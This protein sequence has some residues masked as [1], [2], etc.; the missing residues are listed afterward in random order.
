M[1]KFFSPKVS[2]VIPVYNVEKYLVRCLDSVV[3]IP[4]SGVEVILINDC[5][6]DQS[7]GI[8]D[9]YT[10]RENVRCI[11]H[12]ENKG[13]SAARNTG[14]RA[15]RGKYI[16]FIDGDDFIYPEHVEEVL[17]RAEEMDIEVVATNPIFE[18][19]GNIRRV[20]NR[21]IELEMPCRGID[22]FFKY[23]SP[24]IWN[25]LYRKS[26]LL[27]NSLLFYEGIIH[28]DEEFTPRALALCKRLLYVD[29]PLYHYV[30]QRE[31]SLTSKSAREV[32]IKIQNLDIIIHSL[33][34][35]EE[36]H[37]YLPFTFAGELSCVVYALLL[38]KTVC[39]ILNSSYWKL[40]RK[41]ILHEGS[42]T[43]FLKQKFK[44]RV[45][46]YIMR[47][48]FKMSGMFSGRSRN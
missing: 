48:I 27:A 22:F 26:F 30:Y 42:K 46:Y 44:M 35:F 3:A 34:S 41:I 36:T 32:R 4:V 12:K 29:K 28:E 13:L 7:Q 19:K 11:K 18:Q 39:V 2:I 10:H 14:L 37:N 23:Y 47:F 24:A 33:W 17:R 20:F 8:I 9:K 25:Y 5:S 21:A 16:Y 45:F 6:P 43:Y 31:G 40:L 38:D 15:A 1:S